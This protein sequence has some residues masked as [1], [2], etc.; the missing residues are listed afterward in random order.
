MDERLVRKRRLAVLVYLYVLAALWGVLSGLTVEPA[1]T[2]SA[3]RIAERCMLI[4]ALATQ[5]GFVWFCTVDAKLVG[6]PLVQMAKV[7]IFFG[8]PIGVP[9]YF[10][11]ARGLRGLGMLLLHGLLLWL[12]YFG[13]AVATVCVSHILQP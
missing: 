6:R 11:W 13:A 5:L 12:C 3:T 7:G 8:W 9:I 2:E 4:L 10:V 1:E